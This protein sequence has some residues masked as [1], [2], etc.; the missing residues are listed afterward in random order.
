MTPYIT[1]LA[2][3][4]FNMPVRIGKPLGV[5]GLRDMVD[6]PIY[7][8]AVGLCLYAMDNAPRLGPTNHKDEEKNINSIVERLR[9]WVKEFF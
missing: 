5:G 6:S 9:E 2:A 1:D 8:T 4:I 7:S 3:A